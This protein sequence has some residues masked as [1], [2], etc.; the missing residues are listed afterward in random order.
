MLLTPLHIVY[1]FFVIFTYNRHYDRFNNV[2]TRMMMTNL[3]LIFQ[4][5]GYIKTR[6]HMFIV[7]G[8]YFIQEIY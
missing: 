1:K 5:D 3:D 2:T 4:K 6:D 8:C 7:Q